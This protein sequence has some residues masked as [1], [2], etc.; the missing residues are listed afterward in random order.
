M[1]IIAMSQYLGTRS[2]ELG[3]LAADR[4]GYRFLTADQLI[5]DTSRQYH[6]TPEQ[7]VIVDERRPHFWERL[8]T[9][10]ERFVAF[11]RA[12][13]LK[14]MARDRLVV[15]G[16]SVAHIAPLCGCVLRL[17]LAG[18]FK[19][20]AKEVAREETLSPAV[21][22]RRV[23]DYDREVRARI[24]TLMGVDIEDPANYDLVLNTFALPLETLAAML[25]VLAARIDDSA[26]PE[27]W[28]TLRDAAL[29]AEVRAALMFHPKIGH[30]PL[31]VQ[32]AAG[33]IHVNGPGLVPPWDDLINKVARQ[34][35]GV[36][37]VEVV[38]EEQ[39]VPVRPA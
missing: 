33:V 22:E 27:Q 14:E 7:L 10:T 17:R 20:R 26:G 3:Q 15:I 9:D 39:P 4:L 12:A 13:M 28:R 30:A 31:E 16:R 23:R 2:T 34:V 21:A 1:A 37:S 36:T 38:A 25:D 24:Q 8:K 35:E 6:I 11:F 19:D 5:A 32:C 18:P 29:A